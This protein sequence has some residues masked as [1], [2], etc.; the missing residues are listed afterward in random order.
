MKTY[1]DRFAI[2]CSF[3]KEGMA[4]VDMA[5]RINRDLRVFTLDTG[6][7][8]AETHRMMGLLRERYGIAVEIV[9]PDEAEVAEMVAMHGRDLF[10]ESVDFRQLCC[11]VRKVR[12]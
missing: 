12:P 11:S 9:R 3:Q 6:R 8:P 7:L 1:G 10:R 2:A 5:W 4:I